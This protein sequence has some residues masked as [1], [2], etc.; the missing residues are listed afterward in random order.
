MT[1]GTDQLAADAAG[2]LEFARAARLPQGGFGWLDEKGR[3]D[4][5]RP[6]ETWI[7]ARMTYVFA[8]G[9]L[10]GH[11]GAAELADHGIAALD[12][13]LRDREHGGWLPAVV[14][15]E[16][17]SVP[18][19]KRAYDHAFVVLAAATAATAGR[20]GARA[21]LAD[22][23]DVVDRHFW[24]A[25]DGLAVDVWDRSWSHLEPY[26]GGNA[27]LHLTEAYLAAAEATGD[28]S[29]RRRAL[30][31]LER[32]VHGHARAYDWRLPEHFDEQ[33]RVLPG[34]NRDK[35]AHPFRP[36]GATVGHWL[37]SARLLVHLSVGLS[38]PPAWLL[39]DARALFAAAVRDGWAVDGA[40]GFVYTVDWDGTPV[41]RTRM[42]WVVAEA[43]AAAAVLHRVL[44][45]DQYA[46]WLARWWDYA[47]RY[48]VDRDAGSWHHELDPANRPSATVWSGKP[49]V[50]HTYQA[51]LLTGRPAAATVAA[52]LSR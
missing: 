5:T 15:L 44:G 9:S 12:G 6:V 22:A 16:T 8:L 18:A 23:L 49:D 26:R 41:V 47:E 50:Y 40:D 21:L 10:L 48:L 20:P 1:P 33:W 3:P 42:H 11:P 34:Y 36:Y 39:D 13:L 37:E 7:T 52:S 31:I 17:G 32:L 25:D 4:P 38:D 19:E 27:N 29:L 35:P 51:T 24:R 30:G 2:L 14:D 28:E 45:D 43:I 46:E